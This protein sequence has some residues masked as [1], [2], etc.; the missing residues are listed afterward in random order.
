MASEANERK[1][2]F[3]RDLA[4]GGRCYWLDVT[5]RAGWRARYLKEV[6]SK[7]TT[8]RI[9]QEI[10]DESGKLVEVHQKFPV[11]DGHRKV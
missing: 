7:E 1:F 10:Y 3:W 11:D 6:D 5:G 4:G 2:E 8:L 9:W